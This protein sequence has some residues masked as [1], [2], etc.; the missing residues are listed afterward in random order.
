MTHAIVIRKVG[1]PDALSWEPVSVGEPGP[2]Q[3]RIAQ[4]AVGLNFIDIYHRTGYYPQQTPFTPGLEGAGVVEAIGEGVSHIK[5]GDR[6]A[7]AGPIG[8]YSERRLIAAD[9]LIKL[10]DAISFDQAAAMLLQGMTAQVLLRQVYPVKAG[11]WI[12]IH[13]AAGGTGLIL[14]QWA[15]SL[16][17]KVI[18]TV[19]SDEKAAVARDNGC[20]YPIVYTRQ[21]FVAEVARITGGEKTVVVFDSVGRDTFLRSLD[22][23]RPRGTMVTFG[24]SSGPIEPI[25]PILLS[26]KGSL[27]LTRPF[28]FHFTEKR[29]DLEATAA[30]LFD[31]VQSGKVRINI[32]KRFA[33]RDAAKAQS[34]LEARATTGSI[35]L[36]V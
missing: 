5:V 18:G 36:T 13:A 7:Y 33:L 9:R 30:E 28:L 4:R 17:A 23:L 27:V 19:S 34:E 21:D 1:G 14:C 3:A 16:G 20:K 11:D 22:C 29:A 12:L 10:P 26:Q 8:A 35:V 25:A 15:A 31:V 32:G 24:Q 2:G 6:V